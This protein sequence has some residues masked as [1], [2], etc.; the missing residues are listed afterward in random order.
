[1]QAAVVSWVAAT[2]WLDEYS[3]GCTTAEP[4]VTIAGV[5][6]GGYAAIP[7][8]IALEQIGLRVLSVD[9][10]A[11]PLDPEAA[12]SFAVGKCASPP[13]QLLCCSPV[14]THWS[15]HFTFSPC[16]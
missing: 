6:E 2:K 15:Y 4:T 12:V 5:S 9:A 3:E 11:A 1:M 7:T 8:A 13:G 10:G 16:L 14:C